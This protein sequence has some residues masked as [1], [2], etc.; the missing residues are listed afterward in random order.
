MK[1]QDQR[2]TIR[3]QRTAILL[4]FEN[5][6]MPWQCRTE[7]AADRLEAALRRGAVTEEETEKEE[8]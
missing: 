7:A 4:T 8:E 5:Q 2:V 6:T 3:R 1:E